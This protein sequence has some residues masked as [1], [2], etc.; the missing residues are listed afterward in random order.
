MGGET[1][2][3]PKIMR[4]RYAGQ[5]QRCGA[6]ISAGTVAAYYR[7][8]KSVICQSCESPTLEVNLP[9]A[10]V[11][12]GTPG[13]S[14]RREFQRR[15]DA[16]DS[17]IR[18]N[19][20]VVGGLLLAVTDDPQSTKAWAVGARGE[21][22]L[23][24]LLNAVADDNTHVL[25]DRRIPGTRANIDHIVVS[26]AGVFVIDAKKYQGTPTRRVDGGLFSP[27]RERLFVESR[28]Q[29]KLVEGVQKQV[30]RVAQALDAG[31][32]VDVPIRGVLCF[33]DATWPLFSGAFSISG[34]EVLWPKKAIDLLRRPGIVADETA[35][36]AHRAIARAF[37][38]A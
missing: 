13:A 15:S 22:R 8:S 19:H 7:E 35:T 16:R 9:L 11:P 32:I 23:G 14:A 1:A 27:R 2:G 30:L 18:T 3:A 24:A 34:V 26:S 29:T 36:L 38:M 31:G 4:L 12:A 28:D 17:R 5:C 20:P 37:P 6:A 25:H 21:E 33:V 10:P